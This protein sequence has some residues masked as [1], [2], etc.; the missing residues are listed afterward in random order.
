MGK[1]SYLTSHFPHLML[2]HKYKIA[3]I[4]ICL[5]FFFLALFSSAGF[6]WKNLKYSGNGILA[7]EIPHISGGYYYLKTNRYFI[8]PEHPPLLKDIAGLGEILARPSFPKI[9]DRE[10]LPADFHREEYPIQKT[11]F[12]KALEWANNQD[13][14]GVL[15]LFHPENN[16]DK[17]AFFARL[18]VIFANTLLL[19]FLFFILK[20]IWSA[21][22]AL[23]GLFFFAISQFSIAH[24]SFVVIDF[25]SALLTVVAIIYFSLYLKA[26]SEEEKT[27]KYFWL[28]SI[29]FAAALLSK[30]SSVVLLPAVFL[31]GLVFVSFHP[32]RFKKRRAGVIL[33]YFG[34]YAALTV[35]ALF[36]VSLF[37]AFHVYKMEDSV[38]VQKLY[39]N[40]PEEQLPPIGHKI[41][42]AMIYNN[43]LTKGLAAYI[44][45]VFMVMS[46]MIVSAQS[47][48]FLGHVYGNE[49]AGG[50][51][52]PVL[53]LT[54]L[55]PGLHF[56]SLMA[57]GIFLWSLFSKKDR[58]KNRF[59]D[60]IANPL[61][62]LLFVFAYFY[63]LVTFTSTFQ[64]GLRHIMPVIL[65]AALLTGK[66]V[67][68]FWEM[69]FLKLRIKH[70]ILV[71]AVAMIFSIV[72]SFPYYLQSYNVFAGGTD[73]G[74]KIAT[75]SN[76][77][78]GGSDVRR[79]GKWMRDNNVREIYTQI[80]AD[81][82]LKY[83]LGDGQR[84]YNLQDEGKLP[85]S[86]AYIAVSNYEYMNNV[87]SADIPPERK[88][89]ILEN[90]LVARVGKTIFVYQ[91]P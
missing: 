65:A 67:N 27:A 51:Y 68:S 52:F 7:D 30:F 69:S 11:E 19:F 79:L 18:A 43:P 90:N 44:N 15:Y 28:T 20:K 48:Y 59:L 54:K 70:L 1:I 10:S 33:R 82:P 9:T 49:G 57:L 80:F 91:V 16:P 36:L 3:A 5:L 6:S 78:W 76:Y 77:D 8:N 45:G 35:T 71:V 4:A 47:T 13:Y 32:L 34:A 22:A 53:Y 50:W 55:S 81:V 42:E 25:M 61:A 14:F 73:R 85:P 2:K 37:Y 63:V 60:F 40:Y 66:A 29:F 31:G 38:L 12:P 84:N 88:Y 83:Y 87:Y 39:E 23:L 62:F 58:W 26:F 86:G 75:D 64:I 46:R 74:Y 17:I 89:T 41:L 56:F 72:C 21:R 24:G